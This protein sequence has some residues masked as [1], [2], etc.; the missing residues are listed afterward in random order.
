MSFPGKPIPPDLDR[1]RKLAHDLI[2]AAHNGKG[3]PTQLTADIRQ[4]LQR[5]GYRVRGVGRGIEL[6][7]ARYGFTQLIKDFDYLEEKRIK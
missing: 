3:D 2:D 7:N 1:A 4:Q 6:V 5:M